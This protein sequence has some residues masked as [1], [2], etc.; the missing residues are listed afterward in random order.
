MSNPECTGQIL[1]VALPAKLI[2][3]CSHP[4]KSGPLPLSHGGLRAE[5][6]M[7]KFYFLPAV[8]EVLYGTPTEPRRWH[9]QVNMNHDGMTLVAVEVQRIDSA[10]E[11]QNG[12]VVLHL[13][14]EQ[15]AV[16]DV[17]R[18]FAGRPTAPAYALPGEDLLRDV[19]SI[20]WQGRTAYPFAHLQSQ[21]APY[22]LAL[23]TPWRMP[24]PKVYPELAN[25]NWSTVDEWLF[26]LASRTSLDDYPPHP[27]SREELVGNAL[28]ISASWKALVLSRGA[29]FVG[30]RPDD[31]FHLV[32]ELYVRTVY[33]DSLLFGI[34]Q[35]DR[36]V[37]LAHDAASALGSANVGMNLA[38]LELRLA[39]F[40]SSYWKQVLTTDHRANDLFS[41]FQRQ[42]RMLERY[43][44]VVTE[45]NELNRLVQTQESRQIGAALGILTILGLPLGTALG[46]LQ[47]LGLRSVISL[48][49]A[50][51]SALFTA[52]AMLLTPYGRTVLRSFRTIVP[53][54][55]RRV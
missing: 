27:E 49:T 39:T 42:H 24:L 19:A 33:L 23:V 50:F 53:S 16:L 5:V 28:C 8:A 30:L 26:T 9:I 31:P 4:W 34:I 54:G 2:G 22:T 36:L 45:I 46:I 43:D 41:A 38:S 14:V 35:R 29:A 10:T 21:D 6:G 55:R 12:L 25:L 11:R 3:D 40:R 48:A 47:V 37:E 1:I 20:E 13:R 51:G 52:G 18:Y 32:A 7:R 17:A 15:S 44:R